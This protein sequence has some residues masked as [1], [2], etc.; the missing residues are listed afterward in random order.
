[1]KQGRP[2]KCLLY[3]TIVLLGTLARAG[4]KEQNPVGQWIKERIGRFKEGN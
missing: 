1:M 2:E 4:A 3:L